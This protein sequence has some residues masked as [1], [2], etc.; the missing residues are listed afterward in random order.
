M[1]IILLYFYFVIS[2]YTHIVIISFSMA[3]QNCFR[4]GTMAIIFLLLCCIAFNQIQYILTATK[5]E[6]I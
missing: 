6:K 1:I 5:L 3:D 4:E 2:F